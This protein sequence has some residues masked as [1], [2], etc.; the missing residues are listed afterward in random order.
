MQDTGLLTLHL[1]LRQISSTSVAILATT[2][3][4][5][6][7]SFSFQN[8]TWIGYLN[9]DIDISVGTREIRKYNLVFRWTTS[10]SAVNL[11]TLWGDDRVF[12]VTHCVNARSTHWNRHQS[13]V[14]CS[15]VRLYFGGEEYEGLHPNTCSLIKNNHLYDA[16]NDEIPIRN[17]IG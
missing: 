3:L 17:S 10:L 15:D 16:D 5:T 4:M 7:N 1:E 6:K 8:D 2:R 11:L 9:T 13:L 14:R 12:I